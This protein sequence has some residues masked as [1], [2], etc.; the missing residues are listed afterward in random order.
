MKA[1]DL[2][3]TYNCDNCNNDYDGSEIR[4]MTGDGLATCKHCANDYKAMNR[5]SNLLEE[6]MSVEQVAKIRK[7]MAVI[8]T[9]QNK[10]ANAGVRKQWKTDDILTYNNPIFWSF[11]GAQ[12]VRGFEYDHTQQPFKH[13]FDITRDISRSDQF[14]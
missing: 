8:Q 5:Y 4:Y 10:R 14:V 1:G 9:R 2:K 7:K 12:D 13:E 11:V 6:E 3:G